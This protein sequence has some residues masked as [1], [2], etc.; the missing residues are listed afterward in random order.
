MFDL[1]TKSEL[2]ALP[3]LY[4]INNITPIIYNFL[5][6]YL[7]HL[8]LKDSTLIIPSITLDIVKSSKT[9]NVSLPYSNSYKEYVN[10]EYG[11]LKYNTVP[12]LF[13]VN[14]KTDIGPLIYLLGDVNITKTILYVI[15]QQMKL[16]TDSFAYNTFDGVLNYKNNPEDIIL[17]D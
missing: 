16:V 8:N 17:L 13:L 7:N 12:N 10:W 3:T 14:N 15:S 5:G 6:E 1:P 4:T 11:I 2:L 9:L